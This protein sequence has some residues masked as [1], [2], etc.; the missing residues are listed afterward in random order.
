MSAPSKKNKIK[1]K[2]AQVAQIQLEPSRREAFT[3][4]ITITS[5]LPH[6]SQGSAVSL[7][8]RRAA[9]ALSAFSQCCW[10]ASD[11]LCSFCLHPHSLSPS[12]AAHLQGFPPSPH[13]LQKN[14][15]HW[16]KIIRVFYKTSSSF[17][18]QA[19]SNEM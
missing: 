13:P 18:S 5:V 7:S 16:E 3:L 14:N 12:G 17:S 2:Q 4:Q 8:P 6:L 19:S 10:D 15:T 9:A 1:N 11:S